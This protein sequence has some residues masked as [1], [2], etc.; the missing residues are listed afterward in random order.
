[1]KFYKVLDDYG[2]KVRVRCVCG[3]K[4]TVKIKLRMS[5]VVRIFINGDKVYKN[6]QEFV[7]LS[8]KVDKGDGKSIA[9]FYKFIHNHGSILEQ[10]LVKLLKSK[11]M[12][13]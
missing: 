11:G 6:K 10:D 9:L 4:H 1:M 2:S 7:T 3:M 12:V 13:K 8:E 5:W